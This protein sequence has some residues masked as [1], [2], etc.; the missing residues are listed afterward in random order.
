MSDICK[1]FAPVEN[2]GC[3]ILILGSMPG[4]A[5]WSCSSITGIKITVFGVN[6]RNF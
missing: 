2:A 3:T 4:S 5:R 6:G 1:C